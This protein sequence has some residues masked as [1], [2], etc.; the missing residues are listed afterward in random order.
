MGRGCFCSVIASAPSQHTSP[1]EPELYPP[2]IHT[3]PGVCHGAVLEIGLPWQKSRQRAGSSF[4]SF[5]S[6]FPRSVP[7]SITNQP[8]TPLSLI[9]TRSFLLHTLVPP[10]CASLQKRFRHGRPLFIFLRFLSP[11][12]RARASRRHPRR[13]HAPTASHSTNPPPD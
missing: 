3:C 7:R 13:T 9:P 1:I 2:P 6:S 4:R 5:P 10:C 11:P 8:F 12:F